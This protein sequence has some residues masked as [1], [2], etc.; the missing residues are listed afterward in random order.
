MLQHD[1]PEGIWLRRLHG[2]ADSYGFAIEEHLAHDQH[3]ASQ[4]H[5]DIRQRGIAAEGC[6]EP[7]L[8]QLRGPQTYARHIQSKPS[9]EAWHHAFHDLI[10]ILGV[11]VACIFAHRAKYDEAQANG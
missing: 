1:G 8:A 11:D 4:L 6:D 10:D 5:F 9:G 3:P 2:Q 7:G